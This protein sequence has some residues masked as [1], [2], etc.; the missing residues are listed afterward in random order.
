MK[1]MK[2]Q[3]ILT[4]S[5]YDPKKQLHTFP[6][7]T[8]GN[9][10]F[11]CRGFFEEEQEGIAGLGGIYMAR[12]FGR[13]D[14]R[15]WAGEGRELVNVPNFF[16]MKITIQ[17]QTA[18]ISKK[19][20]KDYSMELDLQHGILNRSYIYTIDGLPAVKLEFQ[21]FASR[22]C[23]Y[24]AGQSVQ[25]TPLLENLDIVVEMGI[26]PDITNLNM[27]SSEPYPVQP[28]RKQ[29]ETLIHTPDLTSVV[30]KKPDEI[31]LAFAQKT[32]IQG[33]AV[34]EAE[35]AHR[36]L[37]QNKK[38]ET[39][40]LKKLVSISLSPED[41]M[42]V[43]KTVK[44]RLAHVSS[45]DEEINAHKEAMRLFWEAAD[46]SLEGN[47]EDQ[48]AIRYNILQ[49]DQSCPSHTNRYSI[50]ARGLTGEMYEG[51]IFWDTE[52]FMLP[53]FSLTA[54]DTAKKLLE[55]R[56]HTL[57]EARKHAKSN[58]FQGAMYGWQVNADGVEQTPQGV[59]AY[60]SIHV[61]ADIAY[62]VLDY[63]NCT[64]D[65]R[66]MLDKGLEILI[67][68][69]RFWAS[70][71]SRRTDGSYDIMAVRGPNEYDVLVNNNLYTNMMARENLI[72]C[73]QVTEQFSQQHPRQLEELM[74]R[75]NLELD[76]METWLDIEKNIILP[77][78]EKLDLWLEDDTYERRMP[79]DMKKAKPTAKRIIDTTIPYE[80][81]PCYQVS[82]QADVLHLMKNLPWYFTKEQ[83]KTAFEF[84]HPKTAFDSSLAY[85]MFSLMAARVGNLE[86]AVTYYE[87]SSRLDIM[88]VQ[89]NTISGLHLANFGGTW[90]ALVFGFAGIQITKD[91]V[92]INPHLPSRWN[93]LTFKLCIKGSWLRFQISH[94]QVRIEHLS[95][96][97]QAVVCQIRETICSL[98]KG[99][100][101]VQDY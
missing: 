88:N 84:Y 67:E 92:F 82:K 65:D 34:L 60:Y 31:R 21:R 81:L 97:E 23:I 36:F 58:W 15:P 1:P 96:K 55:F 87:R 89:L 56:Y 43:E 48:L 93:R 75:L 83:I 29:Y 17:G 90:Q 45:Y 32:E 54:P 94:T 25:V 7:Y 13:A 47:S 37:I 22:S 20:M 95:G 49:L 98:S 76:E 33:G 53:F 99:Q 3:W 6:V 46:I 11:C 70:R 44:K 14:Y 86:K 80:A 73:R 51:S 91:K 68:T 50:G 28:G 66:F 72:L 30:I 69:A 74:T 10:L 19:Q 5:N 52:I 61:I 79:L 77:Y 12:V 41:G 85:S 42:E 16:W 38:G 64:D 101:I 35:T 100:S 78:H 59:G 39:A 18:T 71:V 62:A 4:D 40:V 2:D 9:G 57:D 26:N 24:T 27:V 63:W 8:I